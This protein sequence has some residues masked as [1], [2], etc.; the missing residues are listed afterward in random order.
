MRREPG[1]VPVGERGGGD[2]VEEDREADGGVGREHDRLHVREVG[3][4]D[5][6]RR[7]HDR[8]QATRSE[9]AEERQR[10]PSCSGA[11]HCERDRQH[12]YER[13]T[14][15]GV[16]H[17]RPGEAVERGPQEHRAEDEQS[18][19]V[20]QLA[21]LL[22]EERHLGALGRPVEEAERHAGDKRRD[23]PRPSEG[24][25]DPVRESGACDRNNLEPEAVDQ[26]ALRA[27]GD[28]PSGYAAGDSAA[29]Y[30]VPD[31]LEDE[32][33][34]GG[35]AHLARIRLRDREHDVEQR[36]ADAV[37]ET[38]FDVQAL[39]D[40]G[41]EP[42]LRH[43]GLAECGIGRCEENRKYKRF[44][45]RQ[46]AEQRCR[47]DRT[48]QDREREPDSEQARRNRILLAQ[49]PQVDTRRVGEEHDGQRRLREELH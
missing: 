18:D 34:G 32:C 29:E 12:P 1:R 28:R 45:H 15:D 33:D 48:Q 6:D 46:R 10:R 3:L 43:Y 42:R 30:A 47:D 39:P 20:E 9:P 13:Q 49:R 7:E 41:R 23:E 24:G 4:L 16:E 2:A 11:Q 27:I 19:T 8:G 21:H 38:A 14:E 31:L 35:A 25:C 22:G 44:G 40:P 26:A 17:D 36:D 37:V 5:H